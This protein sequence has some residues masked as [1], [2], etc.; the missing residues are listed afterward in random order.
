MTQFENHAWFV[1]EF[2]PV[3]SGAPCVLVKYA[4]DVYNDN[5][6]EYVGEEY[7]WYAFWAEE[8]FKP[9][10]AI[11]LNADVYEYETL[12]AIAESVTFSEDAFVTVAASD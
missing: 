11:Y 9:L 6:H 10:Y 3:S 4:R 5:T 8:G 12:I 2:T 7:R 1:N